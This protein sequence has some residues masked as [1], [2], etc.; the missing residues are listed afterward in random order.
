MYER[1]L[2]RQRAFNTEHTW[3]LDTV[4]N[5]GNL[6]K[7]QVVD[8]WYRRESQ[9]R[10]SSLRTK[11]IANLGKAIRDTREVIDTNP[12]DRGAWLNKLGSLLKNRYSRTGA[13]AD[14]EE[15]IR[16]TQEAL[17]TIQG[18]DPE[19]NLR[20]KSW[21]HNLGNLLRNRYLRTG[22]I[23]DFEEAFRLI[24]EAT[25]TIRGE[26]LEDCVQRGSCLNN[27]GSLLR[28]RYSRTGA[29]ADLDEATRLTREAIDIF[30]GD[31]SED[32]SEDIG[33]PAAVYDNLGLQ[34]HDRFLRT[35][36]IANIKE[37]VLA[38]REALEITPEHDPN[39]ASRLNNLASR[40][41]DMF[42]RTEAIADLE[43]AIQVTR[44]AIGATLE[45][46][47]NRA[48]W[49][50]NLG[51][52]LGDKFLRTGAIADLDDA[53][54]VIREAIDATPEDD[55]NRAF[56]LNNL[57]SRLSDRFL[58]TGAI[59][60]LDEAIRVTREAIGATP[61]DDPNR[62]LRL[63]SLGNRLGD[64]YSR[65]GAISDLECAVSYHQSALRQS[66]SSAINRIQACRE[67]FR[68][69]AIASD[70]EQAHE[71]SA[72]AVRLIARLNSRSLEYSDKQFIVSQVLGLGSDAA[73][74]AL[75]A[76][77]GPLVAL[78]LLEE[79]RGVLLDELRTDISDLQERHPELAE[80]F[81]HLRDQLEID[82]LNVEIRKRP[83]FEDFLLAPSRKEICAAAKCGPI[84][85]INTCE[86]HCDA[87][88][89]EQHQIRSLALPSL[90][91]KEMRKKARQGRLGSL[92][93]LE[94][95][96]D[97][98]AN[99][100][101][102]ALG[103]SQG[104][105]DGNLPHVWWILTGPLSK[106]PLHA[107]GRHTSGSAETVL[108]RVMSSYS[109]S[110]KTIIAGRRH[111]VRGPPTTD[112][113][114]LVA[115]K[116]TPGCTNLPFAAEEIKKVYDLCKSMLVEPIE[117]KGVKKE[118][119]GHRLLSYKIFHFAGHGQTDNVDPSRS[120]LVL[121]DG[122]LTVA[123]LLEANS[124]T[125]TQ[126]YI[127]RLRHSP[128]QIPRNRS[129]L[130]YLSACGSGQIRNEKFFDESIH[131]ISACQSAGY[132][133]VIGT[134][135]NVNDELCVDMAR[136]TYEGMRDGGMTDD[137]VCRGLHNATRKLRCR[138]LDTLANVKSGHRSVKK[139]DLPSVQDETEA[140][141]AGSRD[142]RDY[143]LTRDIE[144]CSDDSDD[145]DDEERTTSLNWVPYVHF[146][147]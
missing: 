76:G 26:T 14:L 52:R 72:T 146:G 98:V 93:V 50:N 95:L 81:V 18:N 60:D 77:R 143:K 55:S 64:R 105:L 70:W 73:A 13:I 112:Q 42:L 53:I 9:V 25:D 74:A 44:E 4:N 28:Y 84:V 101:L 59:A 100:I 144:L 38:A 20:R 103:F 22:A 99:P 24:R 131:L 138:W 88:L 31:D 107:A 80:Q 46:D 30:Y 54:Q 139:V 129:F 16:L 127:N 108:D 91:T 27:L 120:H 11:A 69:C 115:M 110:I 132:R 126:G 125:Y 86:Y 124:M 130:A 71:A 96:W 34:L 49:L 41:G 133:H 29:I 19:D 39:W 17:H 10:V 79:G 97:V 114:L 145:D 32:D 85:V 92:E 33:I 23:A 7:D 87:V 12:K 51:S 118:I 21:L 94:W 113:A 134:L 45:D 1:A 15:A 90:N 122:K 63:N 136:I 104:T 61:E 6:L 102:D 147:A 137:S 5:S 37:A 142:Q 117:L 67:I 141:N 75:R 82:K 106:F 56:W 47:S 58:R 35:G 3:A 109:S 83:G 111:P 40:L 78:E 2:R 140:Q 123:H 89:I 43:E 57:G 8:S 121:Q 36:A 119:S 128:Y 62:A 116:H 48:S 135:W 65:T 68:Y 66:S